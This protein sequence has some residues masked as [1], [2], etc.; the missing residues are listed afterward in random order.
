MKIKEEA[1]VA[2]FL[3]RKGMRIVGEVKTSG[4]DS[5]VDK[6]SNTLPKVSQ[7]GNFLQSLQHCR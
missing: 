6:V 4:G 2:G 7:M 5:R 1:G 3:E